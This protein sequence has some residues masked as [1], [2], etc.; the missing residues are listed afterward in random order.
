MRPP[1][2]ST[3]SYYFLATGNVLSSTGMDLMQVSGYTI[4][5][6]KLN[7]WR[8]LSHFASVHRHARFLSSSCR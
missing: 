8:Y 5:A 4:V 3:S 1:S 2:S 7:H 6:E